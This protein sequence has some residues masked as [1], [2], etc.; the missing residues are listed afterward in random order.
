V[1]VSMPGSWLEQPDIET[2]SRRERRRTR[3]V[4]D[5]M[6]LTAR[7]VTERGYHNTNLDE[8]ADQL[9]LSKASIY[10]Y[11][12]GKEALVRATL[13]ACAAYVS[14][15]LKDV[16]ASPGTATERLSRLI[17]RQ[18]EIITSE[19]AEAARLFLQPF[20]WPEAIKEDIRGW[21]RE[22]GR[23][24]RQVIADGISDGEFDCPNEV[25]AHMSLQGGMNFVPSWSHPDSDAKKNEQRV[26]D[27]V[28]T[29]MRLVRSDQA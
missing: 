3:K 10:H 4:N 9:D 28:S 11:F 2:G 16:A 23:I 5:L 8:I 20:D 7:M 17:R 27:I 29:L 13:Q 21:Q 19:T 6:L 22:H 14:S 12:N 26:E 1:T 15:Q 25:V 18:L 24:F